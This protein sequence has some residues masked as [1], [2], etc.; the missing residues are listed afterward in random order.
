MS[1][2]HDWFPKGARE[3]AN[4]AVGS[5]NTAAP[6]GAVRTVAINRFA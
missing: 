2:G 1:L 3:T 4:F 6:V 5:P